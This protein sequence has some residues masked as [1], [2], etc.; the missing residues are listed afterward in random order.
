MQFKELTIKN[1]RN[2]KED[3]IDI[4]N[5]NVIF[6]RND[7]G[8]TNFL[9]AIRY[10]FDY[11]LRNKGFEEF[12]YF[13]RDTSQPIE[14]ILKV[15]L[16]NDEDSRYLISKMGG[17]LTFSSDNYIYIKLV[18]KY[19]KSEQYGNVELFWGGDLKD[20]K[21]VPQ[22][23]NFY[24]LDTIFEAVYLD[25]FIDPM[26]LYSSNRNFL[27]K[28]VK[29]DQDDRI[30]NAI[31]H[32]NKTISKDHRVQE[33]SMMLTKKYKDI[34]NEDLEILL[35]SEIEIG[36]TFNHLIPYIARPEEEE[37]LYPTSGDG[38]KKI[39]SYALINYIH[40]LKQEKEQEKIYI[41]LIEEVEN[42][43]HPTMQQAI[44]R[45]L[46][47]KQNGYPYLFMTTHS[48]EMLFYINDVHLIRLFQKEKDITAK[49]V[50]FQVPR[51]FHNSKKIFNRLL[52]QALFADCVLLVEGPSEQI[53]F[54][55]VLEKLAQSKACGVHY[56]ML[57]GIEILDVGGIGFKDYIY[58]LSALNIHLVIKTD[59]DVQKIN[60]EHKLRPLGFNRCLNIVKLPSEH[61]YQINKDNNYYLPNIEIDEKVWDISNKKK[62]QRRLLKN[63][64]DELEMFKRQ[65]VFL[66]KFDLE[67]D[68]M[69]ALKSHP[70]LNNSENFKQYFGRE[71]EMLVSYL[72]NAKRNHMNEFI[73]QNSFNLK[74]AKVIF[75]HKNFAC[76]KALVAGEA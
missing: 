57:E 25:A 44:S 20:L 7:F 56:S 58:I 34:R 33:I 46:F 24:T 72:Q 69:E 28:D 10:L 51:K 49:T 39:L 76:L 18:G 75:S 14:I 9:Y 13:R 43:L 61:E 54:E 5:K 68:L 35:K 19:D 42:S 70:F 11:K 48:M 12:D 22:R 67:F 1:F 27:Y 52:A 41:Y 3:T 38:R 47:D 40:D 59:N 2:F 73:N 65:G 74:I 64:R 31:Y 50:S 4:S 55:A 62:Y 37:N 17:A 15:L 53:L 36:G 66:S 16:E 71:P 32:L 30:Q 29:T 63:Y 21:K 8:K 23:G 6:G 26:K 45:H 60:T